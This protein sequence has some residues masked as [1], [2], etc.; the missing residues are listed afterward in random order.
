MDLKL[1]LQQQLG[2]LGLQQLLP[3]R[4]RRQRHYEER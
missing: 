3:L 1:G 2:L 4:R